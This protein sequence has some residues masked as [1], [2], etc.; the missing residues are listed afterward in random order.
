MKK[1][2]GFTM[3]EL[4]VVIT[5]ISI[6]MTI[7]IKVAGS[8]IDLAR[9]SATE[10]TI[11][12][13]QGILSQ[14]EGELHRFTVKPGVQS[15]AEFGYALTQSNDPSQQ[16]I[17]AVKEMQRHRFPQ[18]PTDFSPDG[19]K[20][21]AINND[22]TVTSTQ[23]LYNAIYDGKRELI[24]D[25]NGTIRENLSIMDEFSPSEVQQMGVSGRL[26]FVDAWGNP[27]RFWRWPTKLFTDPELVTLLFATAP[28]PL[29][30]DPD[31]PLR[32][33]KGF[34]NFEQN[35]HTPATYHCL[36]VMSAGSDG[37]LGFEEP[38]TTAG[39]LCGT[40]SSTDPQAKEHVMDNIVFLKLRA[41]GR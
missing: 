39:R 40:L 8:M 14:K 36:L 7:S 26:G 30:R 3:I 37:F 13:I 20:P 19:T 23:T 31:D 1:R 15:S 11:R 25:Q 6:L 41:G 2:K 17:I 21:W 18:A 27:L 16:K 28:T 33:M 34:G 38:E 4:L 32:R 29:D 22:S 35:Y 5:I 24:K 10:T 9:H 12:K